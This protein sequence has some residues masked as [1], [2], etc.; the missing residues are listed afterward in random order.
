MIEKIDRVFN[1]VEILH[2]LKHHDYL[3]CLDSQNNDRTLSRYTIITCDP[4][5]TITSDEVEVA[6]IFKTFDQLEHKSMYEELP[7]NGGFIGALSYHLLEDIYQIKLE[8]QHKLPKIIGGI[9]DQ[10]IVIDH[11]LEETYI[12]NQSGNLDILRDALNYTPT[13]ITA[14]ATNVE[15]NI[16]ASEYSSKIDAIKDYIAAGDVYEINFTGNYHGTSTISSIDLF[17]RFRQNNPAP[18]AGLLAYEQMTIVSSSPE[19]FFELDNSKIKTQ[20]M[21]G[22]APRTN[23]EQLNSQNLFELQNSS[24]ERSELTMIIDLMRNDLSKICLSDSVKVENPFMIKTYP[25]VYQQVTD[26]VGVLKPDVKYADIIKAL[27]PSGSITGA[28]KLRSI[29][30]IDEL[31]NYAREYYTGAIGYFGYNGKACFNVAIRTAIKCNEHINYSVGGAIVWDST[32][33]S[34]F[35]ELKLKAKGFHDNTK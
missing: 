27:F 5:Q 18:F 29:E 8:H 11:Q 26:V 12:F 22:T 15:L 25:T 28:P 35:A 10:A 30:V 23:D 2:K 9:Y 31:E 21:K 20:P 33:D 3:V 13:A 16:S 4:V 6:E 34:E 7:F 19:L 32:A 17:S 1:P 14:S 24:K